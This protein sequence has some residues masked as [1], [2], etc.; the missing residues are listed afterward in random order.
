MTEDDGYSTL[1]ST[2]AWIP[3]VHKNRIQVPVLRDAS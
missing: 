2:G 1:Y 3:F